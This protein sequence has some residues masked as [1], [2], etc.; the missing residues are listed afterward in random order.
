MRLGEVQGLPSGLRWSG[1]DSFHITAFLAS[2]VL[3]QEPEGKAPTP[4]AGPFNHLFSPCLPFWLQLRV[5]PLLSYRQAY[6][7]VSL[8]SSLLSL[9]SFS[10]RGALA[11]SVLFTLAQNSILGSSSMDSQTTSPRNLSEMQILGPPHQT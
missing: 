5:S 3:R 2:F 11:C 4:S 10:M 7:L 9:P 6:H 8:C 1:W